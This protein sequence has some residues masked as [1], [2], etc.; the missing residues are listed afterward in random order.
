MGLDLDDRHYETPAVP[1]YPYGFP[2]FRRNVRVIARPGCVEH[3][4]P[5]TRSNLDRLSCTISQAHHEQP[6]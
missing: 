4:T 6:S 1:L 5:P 3:L 2:E